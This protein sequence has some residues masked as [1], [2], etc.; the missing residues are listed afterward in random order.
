MPKDPIN[1]LEAQTA[2]A[3][4]ALGVA[5]AQTLAEDDILPRVLATLRKKADNLYR[6]LKMLDRHRR[7]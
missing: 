3:L 2:M 6:H 7:R 1:E 4:A 5:F